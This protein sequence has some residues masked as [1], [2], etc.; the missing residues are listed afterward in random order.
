M[1]VWYKD[2][3]LPQKYLQLSVQESGFDANVYRGRV[4]WG[5]GKN[6][7]GVE[8]EDSS[9]YWIMK[10]S[11]G[12]KVDWESSVVYNSMSW[13][14]FKAQRP[15][16]SV[17]FRVSGQLSDD[18]TGQMYGKNSDYYSIELQSCDADGTLNYLSLWAYVRKASADGKRLFDLLKDGKKRL[19]ILG[20]S[21]PP[22]WNSGY[23]VRVDKFLQDGFIEYG[24]ASEPAQAVNQITIT[25]PKGTNAQIPK[26]KPILNK[27]KAE[28]GYRYIT[29]APAGSDVDS[30][31]SYD[32][33]ESVCR[34]WEA[35]A[36]VMRQAHQEE[37]A[38]H[39]PNIQAMK[40]IVNSTPGASKIPNGTRVKVLGHTSTTCATVKVDLTRIQRADNNS[41]QFI[42]INGGLRKIKQ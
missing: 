27:I 10:T 31:D 26:S 9:D 32:T 11:D 13:A 12:Y 18:F 38:G 25:S 5:R 22:D 21:F 7:F 19:L 36:D 4:V 39:R 28:Q 30:I 1:R 3:K 33:P 17:K 20:L 35:M 37:L 6:L 40:D 15:S 8:V 23:I 42:L 29:H 24:G 2:I 34:V 16:G 41:T 14:A